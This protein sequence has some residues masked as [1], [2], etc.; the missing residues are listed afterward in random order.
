MEK[1]SLFSKVL[2]RFLSVAIL[3]CLLS[4][5]SLFPGNL[6]A[7]AATHPHIQEHACL[8]LSIIVTNVKVVPAPK[9]Q[10]L[11]YEVALKVQNACGATLKPGGTW[12]ISGNGTC[13]FGSFLAFSDGG[14]LTQ[15]PPNN[16]PQTFFDQVYASACNTYENGILVSQTPPSLITVNAHG[17]AQFILNGILYNGVG[18]A[19][20]Q[21]S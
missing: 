8:N 17:E 4:L 14:G 15:L 5:I 21:F 10:A 7:H 9:G 13:P 18:D 3:L 19:F 6:K 2:V 20:T 12:N 11:E 1:K 16:P